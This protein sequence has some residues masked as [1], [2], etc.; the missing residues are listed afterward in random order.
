MVVEVF[1]TLV[2]V[3]LAPAC[4][5]CSTVLS[6]PLSDPVCSSCW[7]SVPWSSPPLCQRCGDA[8]AAATHV[9]TQEVGSSG[10]AMCPRCRRSPPTFSCA[11]SVG[12][13]DG[14]LRALVQALKYGKRRPLAAPLGR[15]MRRAGEDVLAGADVV[16]PVPLHPLRL[17]QRGF[18]QADDLA[19]HLGLPVWRVL[20]RCRHG[21]PQASLPA[22]RRRVSVRGAFALR[23]WPLVRPP[24]LSTPPL[25]VVLID[26]VMTTGATMEACA[27]VLR[28]WGVSEVRVLVTARAVA[29]PIVRH[30]PLPPLASP[31][32]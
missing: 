22:A 14:S 19:V 8:I 20:R 30:R 3:T 11:R 24:T 1:N 16:V 5:A 7:T 27:G 18:N 25:T 31:R 2:R 32:R 17:L 28:E 23:R 12:P 13:Y 6:R 15:L 10:A 9:V 26:D 21:P 4:P 29:A